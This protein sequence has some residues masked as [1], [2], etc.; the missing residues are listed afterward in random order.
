MRAFRLLR[1]ILAVCVLGLF[2]VPAVNAQDGSASDT[3][4]SDFTDNEVESV[5]AAVAAIQDLQRQYQEEHGN[6]ANL[7][8][9]EVAQ[10]REE[11]QS[12]RQQ[13]IQDE[14]ID[15]ST[16]GEV[17]QA[18]QSDTALQSQLYSEIED[19]GGQ[20]PNTQGAQGGGAQQ[21][22]DVSS[23]QIQKAGQA[24]AQIQQVRQKYQSQFGNVQDSTKQQQV[25][26]Q[27]QMATQKAIQSAGL[28]PMQFSQVVKAAQ[29][30]PQ[31]R[32]QFFSA[33]QQAGGQ[34]PRPRQQAPSQGQ[35]PAPSPAPSPG[36]GN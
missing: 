10:I 17:L 16:F 19:A 5:A 18:A 28:T 15:Q 22:P 2:L 11:F 14:G 13:A 36:P 32:K 35:Q 25:Q 27:Y 12:E 29:A 6:P 3:A 33:I 20:T 21:V 34:P 4:G 8:S 23:S 9:S 26:R 1:S 24:F 31:V 30:D 7:D